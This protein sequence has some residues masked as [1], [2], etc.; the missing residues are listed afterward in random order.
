MGVLM[1]FSLRGQAAGRGPRVLKKESRAR[2]RER[3]DV[4]ERPPGRRHAR[5]RAV[6]EQRFDGGQCARRFLVLFLHR[7]TVVA[8]GLVT[9]CSGE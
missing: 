1:R 6:R 3:A 9:G 7:R 4:T 8:Q 5:P 2:A